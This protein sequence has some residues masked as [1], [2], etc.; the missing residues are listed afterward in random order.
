MT[1]ICCPTCHR[2]AIAGL[3]K[4]D[5]RIVTK[6]AL[7]SAPITI[8]EMAVGLS[9]DVVSMPVLISRLRTKIKAHGLTIT[10]NQGGWG[11]HAT[12]SLE[13]VDAELK[14]E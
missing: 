9:V 14:D 5:E 11:Q 4:T 12:Y 7:S 13:R 10:V 1:M 3:S 8:A 6:L 2:P